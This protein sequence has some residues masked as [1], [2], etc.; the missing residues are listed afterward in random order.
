MVIL[1]IIFKY[2]LTKDARKNRIGKNC[3]PVSI[4]EMNFVIQ[5]KRL[6]EFNEAFSKLKSTVNHH[7][8]HMNED[9]LDLRHQTDLE[10]EL[11]KKQIDDHCY[12]LI[13]E[14]DLI[15]SESK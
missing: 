7:D 8:Y 5:K 2:F 12:K 1:F 4:S 13:K 14:L 11:C 3:L 15:E 9:Y 10:R 6:H